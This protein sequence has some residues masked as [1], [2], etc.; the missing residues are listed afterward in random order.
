MPPQPLGVDR[1]APV[2]LICRRDFVSPEL[3]S[4]LIAE[5]EAQRLAVLDPV[6]GWTHRD[7]S[8]FDAVVLD[9]TTFPAS[10][11]CTA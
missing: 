6:T 7:F 4:E 3:L 1:G 2:A 11:G 9:A 5:L 8:E 10:V